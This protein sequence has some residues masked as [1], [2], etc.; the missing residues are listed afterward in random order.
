MT[1]KRLVD[2]I[3]SLTGIIILFPIGIFI[4]IGILLD[5]K[6]PIFF[7]QKRVGK[8]GCLFYIYKYRS[9]TVNNA[10]TQGIIDLDQPSRITKI[11]RILRKTK[12]D[13]IPQLINVLKGE[14]SF[15]GP[16]PEIQKWTEYY[17]EKWKIVHKI[18]PG[19]TDNASIFFRNEE[20]LIRESNDPIN[21]YKNEILPKKLDLYIDYINDNNVWKDFYIIIKTLFTII[22]K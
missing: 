13:E 5:S 16:R 22:S 7:K 1:I 2:I 11:G 3:F 15:V 17:P 20:A 10:A 12:L 6:G 9:M 14:M 4:S 21:L 8:N 19:I 18:A